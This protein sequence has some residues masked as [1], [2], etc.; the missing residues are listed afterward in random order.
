MGKEAVRFARQRFAPERQTARMLEILSALHRA[1]G[2]T[3]EP[4][5]P[6]GR[7]AEGIVLSQPGP[8]VPSKGEGTA[9]SQEV[10]RR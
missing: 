5:T 10:F 9:S 1:R 6:A 7:E 3:M 4:A 8:T 2:K